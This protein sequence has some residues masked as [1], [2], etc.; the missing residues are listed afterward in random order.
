LRSQP[1]KRY[2]EIKFGNIAQLVEHSTE[3]A[4]VVGSIPTV[5]TEKALSKSLRA[6]L[7]SAKNVEVAGEVK[8]SVDRSTG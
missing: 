2:R 5:A 4:G 3:N 1:A 6:F 7:F 8:G